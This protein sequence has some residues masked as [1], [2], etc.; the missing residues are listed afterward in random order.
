MKE[1]PVGLLV[2]KDVRIMYP[3]LFSAERFQDKIENPL[4][5]GVSLILPKGGALLSEYWSIANKAAEFF[6]GSAAKSYMD[7]LEHNKQC[8]CL[9]DG[10]LKT[11]VEGV[12]NAYVLRSITYEKSPPQLL[13][14]NMK[15][16]DESQGKLLSGD[17]A[18]VIVS[19]RATKDKAGDAMRCNLTAVQFEREGG[20]LESSGG[21]G[22]NISDYFKAKLPF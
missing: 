16:L 3:K 14:E 15:V 2:L 18:N 22:I 21:S 13:D 7:R 8:N 19:L 4:R 17:Y 10:D 9:T 20:R 12:E 11:D 5:Y 1:E 6:W